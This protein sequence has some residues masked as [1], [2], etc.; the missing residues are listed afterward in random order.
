M[1][2]IKEFFENIWEWMKEHW[3]DVLLLVVIVVLVCCLNKS[4][5]NAKNQQCIANA[6]II[7]LTDSI[8]YYIGE[9][10]KL[11][12]EKAILIGDKET[13]ELA[14]ADLAQD[15]KDMKVKNA[16]MAAKLKIA[17]TNVKHDTCWQVVDNTL[18]QTWNFDNMPYRK[19]SGSVDLCEQQLSMSVDT[20]QVFLDL[21]VAVED[22]MVKVTSTNPYLSF[23]EMYGINTPEYEP[24]WCLV[25]G[26]CLG[27][28]VGATWNPA[29]DKKIVAGL[30][31]FAGVSLTF[32]WNIIGVGKRVKKVK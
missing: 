27:V 24:T 8:H 18:H 25:V 26:P 1:N 30:T 23:E 17:V 15:L 29:K 3:K 10:D 21:S 19:L 4:C 16:D 5:T 7:A 28:G 22:N 2:Y 13:L 6:N 32:G 9:N 14:Y 12:A 31:G 11:C 20:D